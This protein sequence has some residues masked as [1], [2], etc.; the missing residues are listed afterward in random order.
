M[1]EQFTVK[2]LWPEEHFVIDPS[3]IPIAVGR[4]EAQATGIASVLNEAEEC[5]KRT[6]AAEKSLFEVRQLLDHKNQTANTFMAQVNKLQAELATER[7]RLDWLDQ[8]C[9]FVADA[10]Y[11]LGPFKVGE[12]R[13]LADA[14]RAADF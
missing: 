10:K 11:N 13:K 12:L 2:E 9:S 1:S 8:H 7:E 4:S 14:G 6:S 5:R 3:G